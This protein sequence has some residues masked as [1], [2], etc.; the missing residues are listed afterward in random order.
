M[1]KVCTLFM[2]LIL[3]I[4]L[5]GVA[6]AQNSS[7]TNRSEVKQK[8]TDIRQQA[9][10]EK[11]QIKAEIASTTANAK[12]LRQELKD[13]VEIKIGKKLDAQKLKIANEFE[14]AINN[15]QSLVT[16]IES[17]I[18]KMNADGT[19]TTKANLLLE[20]A[21]TKITL[22]TTE[23][24]NLENILAQQMPSS[25]STSQVSQRKAI[26][27]TINA[28]SNKTKLAIKTAQKA[29]IGVVNSLKPGLQKTKSSTSTEATSTN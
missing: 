18:A 10:E 12:N 27:K 29:I 17:R 6:E 25:T 19:D 16:R 23:V 4:S 22:A 20:T 5:S 26:L 15:L 21:K 9:A 24:T 11:A 3:T 14:N 2:T 7:S 28:E 13:A 1:K 8:I